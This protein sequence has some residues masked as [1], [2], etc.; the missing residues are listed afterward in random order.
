MKFSLKQPSVIPGFGLALGFTLAYLSLI[1]LIPLSGLFLKT[2][3]LTWSKFWETITD[4]R[5]MHAYYI[6]FGCSFIAAL[7]NVILAS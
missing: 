5:I 2:F 4:D 7:I 1:V 3:T 6:T